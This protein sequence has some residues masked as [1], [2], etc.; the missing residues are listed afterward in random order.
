MQKGFIQIPILIAIIVGTIL[1]GAGGYVAIKN[2]NNSDSQK[3]IPEN[4]EVGESDQQIPANEQAS[5]KAC[6]LVVYVSL[7]NELDEDRRL[8]TNTRLEDGSEHIFRLSD[9]VIIP[10]KSNGTPGTVRAMVFADEDEYQK[11]TISQLFKIPGFKGEIEYNSIY[12]E[13][14]EWSPNCYEEIELQEEQKVDKK[15]ISNEDNYESESANDVASVEKVADAVSNEDFKKAVVL[16]ESVI[17]INDFLNNANLSNFEKFCEQAKNLD[18]PTTEETLNE[19]RTGLEEAPI[20]LYESIKLSCDIALDVV[21]DKP[22]G[23]IVISD[24]YNWTKYDD[25]MLFTL[26]NNEDSDTVREQ[27]IMY[28]QAVSELKKY[29][30][31][32]YYLHDSGQGSS[33]KEVA[34]DQLDVTRKI[35]E[36][37]GAYSSMVTKDIESLYQNFIVPEIE[38]RKLREQFE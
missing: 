30:F 1:A 10:K 37:G 4:I 7:Y 22:H 23:S 16:H 9:S 35:E 13:I 36:V 28:N 27:K 38:L 24:S 31:F 6:T 33:L 5:E 18:G 26:T 3:S 17:A 29:S 12:A 8:I 15:D 11:E 2:I 32:A 34:N 25:D 19:A 14:D 21:L 20:P